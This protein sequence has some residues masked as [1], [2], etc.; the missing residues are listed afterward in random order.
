MVGGAQ[1]RD[2]PVVAR[3][4]VALNQ[5]REELGRHG[6]VL[7]RLLVLLAQRLL[8]AVL[9]EHI[10]HAHHHLL[11]VLHVAHARE[12]HGKQA[13]E[14]LAHLLSLPQGVVAEE[15]VEARLHVRVAFHDLLK[16]CDGVLELAQAHERNADVADNLGPNLLASV[17]DL[18]QGHAV[19]LDG[20][21]VLLLLEVDVA[22]VNT[23]A[24][25]LMVL[26]VLDNHR[27]RL[28]S[29]HIEPVGV[30][31]VGEVEEDRIGQVDVDLVREPRLVALLAELALTLARLLG[32]LERLAVPAVEVE[33]RRLLDEAVYLLLHLAAQVLR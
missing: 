17:R 33:L 9:L 4:H 7:G 2:N 24:A 25:A 15:E 28:E 32:F 3:G 10:L 8:E 23:Q 11:L 1:L 27:V 26:L 21:G 29:L 16:G 5:G 6:D 14:D 22:H 20:V 31:L 18:V 19:H 13:R 30:V 12:P